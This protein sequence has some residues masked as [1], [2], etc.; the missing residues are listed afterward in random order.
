[1]R[2][3][4]IQ[5]FTCFYVKE[6]TPEPTARGTWRKRFRGLSP[7]SQRDLQNLGVDFTEIVSRKP[8]AADK[9][10]LTQLLKISL[11]EKTNPT[12]SVIL[13]SG[14]SDFSRALCILNSFGIHTRLIHNDLAT[15]ALKAATTDHISW[16]KFLDL[17]SIIPE[18]R[19]SSS[20][21]S[22]PSPSSQSPPVPF[23]REYPTAGIKNESV[24]C[25]PHSSR[26]KD[27][28]QKPRSGEQ[29]NMREMPP[30]NIHHI[31]KSEKDPD[32]MLQQLRKKVLE[33]QKQ[34]QVRQASSE[35]NTLQ[36]PVKMETIS[37]LLPPPVEH[38]SEEMEDCIIFIPP[39]NEPAMDTPA[40]PTLTIASL[41]AAPIIPIFAPSVAA[42]QPMFPPALLPPSRNSSPVKEKDSTNEPKS[43]RKLRSP[44][45]HSEFGRPC[46]ND[47]LHHRQTSH[48][49]TTAQSTRSPNNSPPF[50][51]HHSRYIPGRRRVVPPRTAM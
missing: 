43:S 40:S 29:R 50:R 35:E 10:I 45:T 12:F 36:H 2:L 15:E 19:Y 18:D 28:H 49:A 39:D 32:L 16:S 17:D 5:D 8:E 47:P 23:R 38:P 1:M 41:Q 33:S 27:D 22:S 42:E 20:P 14:D 25:S 30:V 37:L 7:T 3:G 31:V 44:P 6:S 21:M 11:M 24:W 9:F 13:I 51:K 34:R 26:R 4:R 48:G 46:A